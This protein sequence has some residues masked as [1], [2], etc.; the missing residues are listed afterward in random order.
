MS[1]LVNA[2]IFKYP[3]TPHLESSRLQP[4]DED[5]DA[6]PFS[7][8]RGEYAVVEEKID[9][10]NAAFSFDEAGELRLQSRGHYLTGGAREKQFSLFKTWAQAHADKFLERFEDRYTV[11][12]EWCFALHSCWYD[13]LPGYFLEFDI[14]DRTTGEFLSTTRRRALTKGLPIVSVPVLGTGRFQRL[15]DITGLVGP[16]LYKSPNWRESLRAATARAG[17]DYERTL[18]RIDASELAEGL[19]I[20]IETETEVVARLKWIRAG[21]LQIIASSGSHWADRPLVQNGLAPGVDIFA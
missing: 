6:V 3:R 20:K 13:R 14:L 2:E 4:G 9:G 21:F 1:G 18:A 5:L 7:T 12:G 11:Y 10:A 17:V 19:Y 8:I 16:S 15:A